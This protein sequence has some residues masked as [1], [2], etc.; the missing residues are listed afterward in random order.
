MKAIHEESSRALLESADPERPVETGQAVESTEAI[1]IQKRSLASHAFGVAPGD[2]IGRHVIVGLLDPGS[3]AYVFRAVDPELERDVV[4]KMSAQ[5]RD[6]PWDTSERLWREGQL[7]ARLDDPRLPRVLDFGFHDDHPYL[8]LELIR[9]PTLER[10]AAWG[11]ICPRRAARLVADAAMAADAAHRQGIVHLDIKPRNI[12]IDEHGTARLIDFGMARSRFST[13]PGRTAGE[14]AGTIPFMSPEQACDE[15]V[16]P[17][18]D[19]FSLG[20]TL[21]VTLTGR[22][23][24]D[25]TTLGEALERARRCDFDRDAL[26]GAGVPVE[27]AAICLRAMAADWR[28]RF[29][30]AAELAQALESFASRPRRLRRSLVIALTAA[31]AAITSAAV[32]IGAW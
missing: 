29:P 25:G 15:D 23:A 17:E 7:L 22:L 9:G 4:I 21:Y 26:T 16:R 13:G 20:A 24:Y 2:R 31:A 32:S 8:V 30:S 6:D 18:S 5:P 1:E 19:V 27:L 10:A 11:R 12:V 14:V 28:A 3:Q